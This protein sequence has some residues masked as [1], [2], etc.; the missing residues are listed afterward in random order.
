MKKSFVDIDNARE[1]E[2]KKVMQDIIKSDHCPFCEENLGKYHSE[3]MIK[4]GKFWIL[5]KN[6]WP[7]DHTKLHLLVIYKEHVTNLAGLDP[8]AGKELFEFLKWAEKEYVIPGGGLAMRFGDTNYSAGTV[9]HLHA[10]LVQ[11]DL[12]SPGYEPVRIKIGKN[13]SKVVE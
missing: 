7:Y 11:P 9:N 13:F 5:T 3:T 4:E 1:E 2:Q 10:Q 8:E 12:D 6:K